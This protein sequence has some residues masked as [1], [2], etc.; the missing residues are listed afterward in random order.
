M[1]FF[2]LL[3]LI[4]LVVVAIPP[5]I[6]LLNRRRYQVVDWGAMQFLQVSEVT[7]RRMMIEEVLLMVLRMGLLAL[8]VLALAGPYLT[9]TIMTRLGSRPNRDVVLIFDGSYSMGATGKTRQEDGEGGKTPHE[10]A[11]EWALAFVEDLAPGD[12]VAILQAK[13]QVVPILDELSQNRDRIKEHLKEKL[14]PPA[15]GCNW[16]PALQR[17]HLLLAQSQRAEREIIL[18]GDG[19]RFSWS[20]PDTLKRWQYLKGELGYANE[21]SEET[22]NP[23][24]R[25]WVVN[26]ASDRP[27]DPS[28]WALGTLR[29]NRPVVSVKRQVKFRTEM[30]LH[31]QE[32][33]T[34]PHKVRV[35][36]DGNHVLDVQM[37]RQANLDNGKVPLEFSHRF[38]T[39]GS[40]LVTLTLEADPPKGERPPG[41][42]L[43]DTVPGDNQQYF[44]VE[45]VKALPVLIV[46]DDRPTARYRRSDFLRTALAPGKDANSAVTVRVVSVSDFDPAM[47]QGPLADRLAGQNGHPEEAAGVEEG[48]PRVLILSN[49]SRLSDPQIAAIDRYLAEGGGVL[50]TLGDR[51]DRDH[52]NEKL[53]RSGE[54]W[55][56]AHLDKIEG[57]EDKPEDGVRPAPGSTNHPTLELFRQMSTGGL[58]VA[59]FPRWWSVNTP[60]RHAPGVP[61]ASLRSASAEYPFLV[62]RAYPDSKQQSQRRAPGRV[63][64]CAVPLDHS[65]GTNLTG[66]A[67]FVPLVHELVY[68]L[69]GA[70]SADFNLQA[71]QPL[72]YRIVAD[73]STS[74]AAFE[75]ETTLDRWK[76]LPP[77]GEEH[78]LHAPPAKP[79][80]YPAQIHR[81]PRDSVLVYTDTRETGVYRLTTPQDQS[82]YYVVQPDARESDLAPADEKERESIAEE[83]PFRYENDRNEIVQV[84]VSESHRQELWWL[85]LAGVI[86]LLCGELWMTRRMALNR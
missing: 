21:S 40:H 4:G 17:A 73:P 5:L 63:L 69:A 67:A 81:Q 8:L 43:K 28:N 46:D 50:L 32:A 42:V 25:L 9:S 19:Q 49:V 76:L 39:P 15:G 56:P 31:G 35:A 6:H 78:P 82:I 1:G 20:D 84:W 36:V 77:V 54:G 37:P 85:L 59:S 18:L 45:V 47:L 41:Y 55:L 38:V 29:S 60:G 16:R 57:D 7:R 62:E 26:L 2:N 68:Y 13:Q 53:Y 23:T 27:A 58:A 22:E 48:R 79:N 75:P 71:G 52:Y 33:Y 66:A 12:G 14:P 24:P 30:I 86:L 61:V 3:M 74:T 44:A 83:M 70:R 72:R 80:T 64:L 34:P 51:V 10:K 65:W 11:R